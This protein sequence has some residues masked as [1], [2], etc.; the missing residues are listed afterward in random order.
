VYTRHTWRGETAGQVSAC[1]AASTLE[2]MYADSRAPDEFPFNLYTGATVTDPMH[3][4]FSFVPC[5]PSTAEARGFRRP[6]VNLDGIT[7]RNLAQ[8]YR[9]TRLDIEAIS[10]AWHSV[11]EQVH[12]AGLCLGFDIAEPIEQAVPDHAWPGADTSGRVRSATC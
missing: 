2:P 4:M 9:A 8:G 12:D 6:F 7:T 3:G 1:Y 11:V 10:D 5:M